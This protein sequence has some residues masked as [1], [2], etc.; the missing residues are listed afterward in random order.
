MGCCC[1]LPSCGDCGGNANV[2][3]V[4]P[5]WSAWIYYIGFLLISIISWV[6]RD[7]GGNS[8]DVGGASGCSASGTCGDLA[9]LR[10]SFGSMIFFAFMGLI[11]LGVTDVDNPR[12]VL[13]TGLW[14]I[15]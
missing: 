1:C 9:V 13:H 15:K 7:Y 12:A 3:G 14:P 8:L 5:K 11:T 4:P 10:L 2:C 6:L